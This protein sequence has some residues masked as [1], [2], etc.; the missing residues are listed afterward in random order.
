VE[1]RG[2]ASNRNKAATAARATFCAPHRSA[3]EPHSAALARHAVSGTARE[4]KKNG[5]AERDR[6]ADLVI[7]NDALSQLSYSPTQSVS[8]I[9]G[10]QLSGSET[11]QVKTWSTCLI[12]SN[13]VLQPHKRP[14]FTRYLAQTGCSEKRKFSCSEAKARSARAVSGRARM[15]D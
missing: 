11:R 7:A 3:S 9:S 12:S 5:G 14:E 15:Q 2:E 13:Q 4:I 6:T 10:Y 1:V 8:R